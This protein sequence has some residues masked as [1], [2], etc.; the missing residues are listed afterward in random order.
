MTP[1]FQ[2]FHYALKNFRCS[3]LE[4]KNMRVH[5]LILFL[6]LIA[7]AIVVKEKKHH[8]LTENV[9]LSDEIS[10]LRR[11]NTRLIHEVLH[12]REELQ[13]YE[14]NRQMPPAPPSSQSE[15]SEI[16]DLSI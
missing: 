11:L 12:L 14:A 4:I 1:L 7:D 15:W 2:R 9:G 16:F 8:P 3:Y 10:S 6:S 13:R 5:L